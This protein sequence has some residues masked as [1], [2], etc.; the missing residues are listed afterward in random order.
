M[1]ILFLHLSL[2]EHGELYHKCPYVLTCFGV[3]VN[4]LISK[5]W[6]CTEL[7]YHHLIN[8]FLYL[9]YYLLLYIFYHRTDNDGPT[10][11]ITGPAPTGCGPEHGPGGRRRDPRR[12]I[13]QG[14]GASPAAIF[15]VVVAARARKWVGEGEDGCGRPEK[16]GI[17]FIPETKQ[18][19]IW[20]LGLV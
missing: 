18:K 5:V 4:C 1:S 15:V 14:G 20:P 7:P 3:A 17:D 19:Q 9:T 6:W 2:I 13:L 10:R 16:I 11:P 12:P 8:S